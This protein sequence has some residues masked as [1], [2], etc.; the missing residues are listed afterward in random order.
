MTER[1]KMRAIAASRLGSLDDYVEVNLD[2]P[3]VV[4]GQL[5]VAVSAVGLGYVD[6][7]IACGGYQ[8]KPPLPHVPGTEIVGR[9]AAIGPEVTGW[10]IGDRVLAMAPHALADFVAAPAAIAL[11][12]PHAVSD[13]LAAS[14]PLNY[15]T[16]IHGLVDRAKL[17]P[18]ECL[19]VLGAAG[20]VGSA[21]IQVGRALDAYVIAAASSEAKRAFALHHGAHATIDTEEPGWRDRLKAI[22]GGRSLDV[23]FDP[24]CGP[25]FQPVFR[26][27]G[28]RGRHLVVGFVGGPTLRCRAISS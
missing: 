20:G 25:L 1:P 13:G 28:W 12:V 22:L 5:L 10:A 23:A 8:V 4:A 18:G 14:L 24:V 27:L 2:I 15:L 26:S 17:R 16:A 9:V 11:H 21:A 19:L 3:E 7:L 6:A